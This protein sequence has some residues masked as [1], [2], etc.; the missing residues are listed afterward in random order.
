MSRTSFDVAVILGTRPE[1]IK[2]APVVHALRA[3][4]LSVR[5]VSSG[6]H[7]ELA[8][9]ALESFGLEPDVDLHAMRAE[10]SLPDLMARLLTSLG[11][12]LES[13]RP[14]LALVQGD[15]ATTLA[16]ALAC[17]YLHLPCL[18]VEAGLRTGRLD[19]PW[20][21]EMNR[22]LTDRLCTRH[23][24]P[25]A[26]ARQNL[27]REGFDPS[28][29]VVT[30]QTGVDAAL[31]I[32][33]RMPRGLPAELQG[34]LPEDGARIVYCTEHRREN[35][36]G[37]IHDVVSALHS[38]VSDRH[39]VR[40]IL[41]A[42]PNPAVRRQLHDLVGRHER[43][44]IISPVSYACSIWL[45]QH[46]AAIVTDSGGI[47]EEA[48]S[49]GVPVLVTRE[50]TER[51]EGIEAGFLRISGTR[52]DSVIHHLQQVLDDPGLR[53][54]LRQ[55]SNPFG[56]GRASERIAEDVEHVLRAARA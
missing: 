39:D 38:V 8:R 7:Q 19:A 11:A 1:A 35:L 55:R 25:T 48:P 50:V 10:Q 52:P 37:A 30:G 23:Y 54:T 17:H 33:S 34:I 21:E 45:M 32:A 6:Q 47:Q 14:R 13:A 43:L 2:L 41:P 56:D 16:G 22:C 24:P 26:W 31:D 49:F 46:A 28:G 5:L 29:M 3:K 44:L 27:I 42:H 4:G 12:E 9:G 18:H 20:P 40:V 51:P 36:D 15:A 53:Q